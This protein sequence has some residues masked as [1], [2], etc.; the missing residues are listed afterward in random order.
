M[1]PGRFAAPRIGD[2]AG[3]PARPAA[4]RVLDPGQIL[5]R[6][7]RFDGTELRVSLHH[8]NGDPARPFVRIGLWQSTRDDAWPVKGKGIT[9]KAH[10]LSKVS[11]ALLGALEATEAT[12]AAA[13]GDGR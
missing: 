5:F 10:E 13:R 7:R 2:G 8:F 9:V 12:A 1:T 4:S 6:S 3:P 11:A